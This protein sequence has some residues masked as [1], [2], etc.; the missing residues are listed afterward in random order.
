MPDIIGPTGPAR[1]SA[2]VELRDWTE[3]HSANDNANENAWN[4][5]GIPS[6]PNQT[7]WQSEGAALPVATK[8]SNLGMTVYRLA[9]G[10][11][12]GAGGFFKNQVGMPLSWRY[13]QAPMQ[14]PFGIFGPTRRWR[15][16]ATLWTET[17]EAGTRISFGVI[18]GNQSLQDNGDVTGYEIV[19]TNGGA[20]EVHRRLVSAGAIGVIAIPASVNSLT[21]QAWEWVY[22]EGVTPA[23]QLL[24]NGVLV[25]TFSGAVAMPAQNASVVFGSFFPRWNYRN[26]AAGGAVLKMVG[27]HYI[28]EFA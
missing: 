11:G 14:L 18:C 12:P 3:M 4:L 5:A 15:L 24:R 16:G 26:G 6:Q 10:A 25:A 13:N 8:D 2:I 22:T 28:I 20:W 1:G 9:P 19:S 7:F 23:L 17:P 27:G 21:P